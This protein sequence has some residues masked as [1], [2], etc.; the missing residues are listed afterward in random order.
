MMMEEGSTFE[1]YIISSAV[2][3]Q[4]GTLVS[5]VYCDEYSYEG[6]K[7]WSPIGLLLVE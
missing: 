1:D 5:M 3:I 6:A 4:T 7:L 2:F